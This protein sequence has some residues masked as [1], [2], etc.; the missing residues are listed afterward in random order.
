[1]TR[2]TKTPPTMTTTG[3]APVADNRNSLTA[4][5]RGPAA[6]SAGPWVWTPSHSD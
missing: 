2:P 1:M 3:G 5:P 6:G 4:G